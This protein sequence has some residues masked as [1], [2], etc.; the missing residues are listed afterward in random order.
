MGVDAAIALYGACPHGHPWTPV[1][2]YINPSS[3]RR[4][5]R[6][7][8]RLRSRVDAEL[9]PKRK[10]VK[11]GTLYTYRKKKCRC[12]ECRAA[13]TQHKARYRARKRAA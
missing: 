5:C 6:T 7:C 11:H 10:P 12:D 9:H 2:S 8:G 1:N 3:L 4:T 13:E